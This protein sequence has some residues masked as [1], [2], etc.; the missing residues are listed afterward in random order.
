[1]IAKLNAQINEGV[2]SPEFKAALAK[3]SNEPLGGTPQD[4]TNTI[5]ARHREVG[6][7]RD[8]RSGSRRSS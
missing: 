7:D 2:K 5:K 4:F 3:L 6:A 1:M 8:V